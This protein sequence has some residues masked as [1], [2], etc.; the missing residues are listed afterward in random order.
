MEE[1]SIFDVGI[2]GNTKCVYNEDKK[3]NNTRS[4]I[5]CFER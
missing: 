5:G 2:I 3:R 4:N 1:Y